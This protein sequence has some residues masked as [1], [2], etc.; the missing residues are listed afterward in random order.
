MERE[1]SRI[2][3]AVSLAEREIDLI[4]EF[5][6]ALISE[7]VTGNTDVHAILEEGDLNKTNNEML[8]KEALLGASCLKEAG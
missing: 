7:A 2:D 1:Q 3:L 5:R 6:T 8:E 4:K